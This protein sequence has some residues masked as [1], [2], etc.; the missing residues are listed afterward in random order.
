VARLIPC[1]QIVSWD[2]RSVLR[3]ALIPQPTDQ[4]PSVRMTPVV[5]LAALAGAYGNT[6]I[7]V[8]ISVGMAL[9]VGH[10]SGYLRPAIQLPCRCGREEASVGSI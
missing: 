3:F 8:F 2:E 5:R 1:L 7:A 4:Q 6:L 10:V 9:V